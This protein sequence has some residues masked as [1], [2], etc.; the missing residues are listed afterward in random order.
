[1]MAFKD[2]FVEIAKMFREL[3]EAMR[4]NTEATDRIA[5]EIK[6]YRESIQDPKLKY[7]GSL[8]IDKV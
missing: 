5:D 8:E 7:D 3:A 6:K 4:K 2:T 1:M